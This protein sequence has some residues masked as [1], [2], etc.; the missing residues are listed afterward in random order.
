MAGWLRRLGRPSRVLA[1]LA[2][3]LAVAFVARRFFPIGGSGPA[4]T[5]PPWEAPVV[6]PAGATERVGRAAVVCGRV[7]QARYLPGVEGRPTFLNFGGRHP[8]QAFT[9]VIWGRHRAA[10]GFPPERAYRG[11]RLCVAGSVRRHEGIPQIEV[12]TPDQIGV[13]G[14]TRSDD[15]LTPPGDGA[16]TEGAIPARETAED[17]PG[18]SAWMKRGDPEWQSVC[19]G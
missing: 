11:R 2:L 5:T 18:V 10:F 15:T 12:R 13:R 3:A 1:W 16:P 17:G 19:S 8:H 14:K 6:S 9:A 4:G 7:E